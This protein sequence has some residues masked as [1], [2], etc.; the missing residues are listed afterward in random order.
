MPSTA[1]ENR[2][3]YTTFCDTLVDFVLF[4][5]SNKLVKLTETTYVM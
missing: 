2:Y 4:T 3:N 5:G 1:L